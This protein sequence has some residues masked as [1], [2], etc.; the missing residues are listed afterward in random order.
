[1]AT[2]SQK[3]IPRS[4]NPRVQIEYDVELYGASKSVKLPFVLG[5]LAD[6][7]GMSQAGVLPLPERKFLDVD[8]DTFE[9]RLGAIKPVLSFTVPDTT[10][11]NGL[12]QVDLQFARLADFGPA[13]V[14][15]KVDALRDLLVSR[16]QLSSLVTFMDG[17]SGAEA[18]ISEVLSDRSLLASIVNPASADAQRH[19]SNELQDLVPRLTKEFRP[20]TADAQRAMEI[21]FLTLA[22]QAHDHADL[23]QADAIDTVESMIIRLDMKLSLQ[24]NLIIHHP[25]FTRLEGA[26]RGLHYLVNN[27][28]SDES[29]KIRF[30]NITKRDLGKIILK[31][32]GS[33]WKDSPLQRWIY[34]ENLEQFGGEPFACLI[35][36]YHFDDSSEDAMIL[37]GIARIAAD[38]NAPFLAGAAPALCGYESW[39]RFVS[40]A[41]LESPESKS[42]SWRRLRNSDES[43]YIGLALPRFLARPSY[44]A[45]TNPVDEF[46]F[47]EDHGRGDYHQYTWCNS[48]YAMAVNIARAFELYG[49]CARIAG[50]E[51][52]G[53]VEGLP[54]RNVPVDADASNSRSPVEIAITDRREAELAR[55]GL[56]ALVHRPNSDFAA[57]VGAQSF[58]LPPRYE[59]S[60]A[61]VNAAMAARLPYLFP[62]CRFMHYA[63]C[64]ARDQIGSFQG[65]EE[66][67]RW[68]QSWINQYVDPD[69]NNSSE[70]IR[71]LRPLASAEIQV[72]DVE[73]NPGYFTI[74]MYL[75]P[76]Y[77]LEWLQV[78]MR[79]VSR[80]TSAKAVT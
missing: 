49:W 43:R 69:P 21:A 59:D 8:F 40:A 11:G 30:L 80:L 52:G 5:V 32:A 14:A 48:A 19:P 66:T 25:E 27:V 13:G 62:C 37:H 60:D 61:T 23:V 3:F 58:Q 10:S 36:D 1:M 72:S 6:L 41:G 67:Q 29:L 46:D 65:A 75:R 44:G 53:A 34:D 76:H 64:I 77:Q 68:L 4:R 24:L 74:R 20:K 78:S 35:G 26:W 28:E 12:L 9:R 73:G 33:S 18:L 42:E 71:A 31:F 51:S 47:E 56:M 2:S 39:E 7:S 57:F 70:A 15:L 22:R 16:Q 45:S 63:K 54:I 55:A 17:K 38:A 50:V 79:I